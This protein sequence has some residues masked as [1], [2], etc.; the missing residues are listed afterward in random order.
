M[1]TVRVHNF[2]ISLD[3]YG[4]GADDG[5]TGW[6]GDEPP[7]HTPVFVLT[8]HPREPL[9]MA[10]RT[11]F[12]FVDATPAEALELARGERLWDGLEGIEERFAVE[13]VASP[14]GVVHRTFT[15]AAR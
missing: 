12:H 5:W 6:W 1:S 15:R 4:A 7:F 11:T 3:G 10:G 8:H 9:E 14:S 2:A 13:T